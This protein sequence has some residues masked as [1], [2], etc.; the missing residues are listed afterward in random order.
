M[1]TSTAPPPYGLR[2]TVAGPPVQ[3]G[4]GITTC[5]SGER[6]TVDDTFHNLLSPIGSQF[7]LGRPYGKVDTDHCR[8]SEQGARPYGLRHA[9]EMAGTVM[10]TSIIGY[11]PARQIGVI[12]DPNG[13]WLP[14]MRHSTG[15]TSTT[16]G[17]CKGGPDSDTDAT[18]D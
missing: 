12:R 10:D 16:T 11:D 13:T 1:L 15:T 9:S 2:F 14:V 6:V 4:A 18:E 8:P 17:D 7:P 3:P 5:T